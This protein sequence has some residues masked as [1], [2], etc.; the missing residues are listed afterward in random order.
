LNHVVFR[1]DAS[2]RIGAG[3]V[4]RCLTLAEALN[5][6]G[7][8]CSFACGEETVD[9][10]PLL[11]RSN[12]RLIELGADSD[13]DLLVVDHYRL[14]A[15][16]EESCR[17]FAKRIL[18][19]DDLADRSH[20][21]D[22]LLDQTFGRE[23]VEYADLVPA[24]CTVLTGSKYALVRSMFRSARPEALE[25]RAADGEVRR[26]LVSL[27]STDPYN[28]TS[29]VLRSLSGLSN[30]V[31]VDVVLGGNAP[32]LKNVQALA[33]S[34][35]LD[36]S[37]HVDCGDMAGRIQGADLAIGAAG[38]SSWERCCLGLPTLMVIIA[39]NQERIA[40]GLDGAGAAVNLGQAHEINERQIAM[41][42]ENMM[43]A[44]EKLKNM[45]A[46][47]SALCD[48]RGTERVIDIIN[49]HNGF[50]GNTLP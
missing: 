49:T 17:A 37:I 21:C 5:E 8:H 9:T 48:G 19:I 3:H 32:H 15:V 38:S 33:E 42:I 10:V 12:H 16:F 50:H 30:P 22:L 40:A 36:I 39:A 14:D 47:A 13:I 43:K 29:M 46:K 26:V 24:D 20:D 41:A 28:V 18:V 34:L 1:A 2:A 4:M 35:S 45:S 31:K 27:G 23:A 44:P 7:W 25:R 11:G 6:H